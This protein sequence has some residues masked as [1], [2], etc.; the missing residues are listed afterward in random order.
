MRGCIC[1]FPLLV[2]GLRLFLFFCFK[3]LSVG[4]QKEPSRITTEIRFFKKLPV[5]LQLLSCSESF[6]TMLNLFAHLETFFFL[7]CCSFRVLKRKDQL[8]QRA[9]RK[10]V[11]SSKINILKNL[12]LEALAQ[13]IQSGLCY[14]WW[15]I[16]Y[17]VFC[18]GLAIGNQELL[19]NYCKEK[20]LG[21]DWPTYSII[22]V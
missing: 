10:F 19:P 21:K 13:K 12:K 7:L 6:P 15:I 9:Q 20:D 4:R 16:C 17:Q 3:Q 8:T 14:Q 5:S 11:F 1:C 22:L 2:R 18:H